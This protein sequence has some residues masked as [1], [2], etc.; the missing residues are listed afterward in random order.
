MT[1]VSVTAVS[2]TVTVVENGATVVVPVPETSVVTATTAGPQGP[3]GPPGPAGSGGLVVD[4]TAT[5]DKSI[6]YYDAGSSSFRADSIWTT[7]TLS[8]GGNF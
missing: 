3:S 8:D 6:V 7:S 5:V 1:S 4:T 2:T